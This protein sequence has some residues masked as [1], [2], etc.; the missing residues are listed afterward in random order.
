MKDE[1]ST[2]PEPVSPEDLMRYLDGEVTA[3]ERERIEARL[4]A[5]TELQRELVVF[6]ELKGD[7]L[8]LSFRVRPNGRSAWDAVQRKL[9]RPLGWILLA[10][11]A[12]LWLA[13]GVW[14]WFTAPGE[15]VEKLAAGGVGIGI[16]LLLASVILEQYRRWLTD[17]Y[18][19]VHR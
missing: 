13:Y 4:A 11:G 19:D 10:V 18:R 7:L 16:L 1:P 3:E 5:S 9:T 6:R 17:P 15:L 12:T 8:G 14:A 2:R